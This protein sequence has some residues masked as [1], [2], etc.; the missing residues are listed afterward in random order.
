ML[1]PL[2][3]GAETA[4]AMVAHEGSFRVPLLWR[5]VGS[6]LDPFVLAVAEKEGR[7]VAADAVV[8]KRVQNFAAVAAASAAGTLLQQLPPRSATA[9]AM[10]FPQPMD[11]CPCFL[12]RIAALGM[13]LSKKVSRA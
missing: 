3:R 7:A 4:A 10:L 11:V 1:V 13:T 9:S 8:G 2:P 12:F 5:G 6:W